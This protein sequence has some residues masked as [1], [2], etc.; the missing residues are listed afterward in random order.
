MKATLKCDVEITVVTGLNEDSEPI[1]NIRVLTAGTEIHFQ[2]VDYA[3]RFDAS[4]GELVPDLQMWNI[5]FLDGSMAFGVSAEWLDVH[6]EPL[7]A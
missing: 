1:E 6:P 7:A 2:L 4:E 3:M 5:Q